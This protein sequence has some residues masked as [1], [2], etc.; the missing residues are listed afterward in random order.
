M[1]KE[2]IAGNSFTRTFR[3]R[4]AAPVPPTGVLNEFAIYAVF[5]DGVTQWRVIVLSFYGGGYVLS[6]QFNRFIRIN[7]RNWEEE[8]KQILAIP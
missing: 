2:F 4:V 7:N 5:S 3:S 1:L 6:G 8:I